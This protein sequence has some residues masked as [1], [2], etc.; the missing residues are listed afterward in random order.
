[1]V[2][3]FN[4]WRLS[5]K[6]LVA[7]AVIGFLLA[8]VTAAGIFAMWELGAIAT[9]HVERGIGGTE[10]L[11]RLTSAL[12]EHRI[13]IWSQTS[14]TSPQEERSYQDRFEKNKRDIADAL[15]HYAP[16]AGE[17]S[18]KLDALKRNITALE[19]VNARIFELHR[20]GAGAELSLIKGEGRRASETALGSAVDLVTA[21]QARA[22]V[23]NEKGQAFSAKIFA[24]VLALAAFGMAML[25]AIWRLIGKTVST[26]MAELSKA[27][28]T[29]ADG[30][31]AVVP[32]RARADELGEVAQAVEQFRIAAVSRAEADARAA[33]EQEV[34]TSSL[35]DGLSALSGGDL[36][37]EITRDFP[38]AYAELKS[39]FNEALVS[40]RRLIGAVMESTATIRTGSGEIAQA[41][42]DLA[43]RTEAN[44]AS[45]EETS[46]AIAQIDGR[47]KATAEAADRTVARAD[48]AITTVNGGRGIADEAVEAMNRVSESAK[49]IDDVI[50]G[51]DKIAFQTRVLAMNAAV[52]AGRA[53]EAGRGF[54]VVA[55]LVS[56]LAMRAEEEAGRAREQLT[57][58]RTDI[59]AAVEM[60]QK[61]DGAL[62][63]IS[64]DV[65]EVHALLGQMA[66]DNQ[67]QSTAITQIS[68][69]V[70]TMDQS[71]QQNAAMVEETSAAARNLSV[72]VT[73]LSEQA[74]KFNLGADTG[75]ASRETRDRQTSPRTRPILAPRSRTPMLAGA[76]A[77]G[78]WASF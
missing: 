59:V 7:F 61:V 54:A 32:H 10:A 9:R 71:T 27:T 13:I 14:A 24:A 22:K 44:A 57:A 43:R 21:H 4:S 30:G 31:E 8:S 41:S 64:S 33:A 69:A 77:A 37:C 1:M 23:N 19:Q 26:P 29:L 15:G 35:R 53:G 66:N 16:L 74:E 28:K 18:P 3:V 60:V 12:R 39:N 45:L 34:V 65:G 47:L 42:E 50:E 78:D 58:T 49:G 75:P 11:G 25:F 48:G 51:L 40:L 2:Q 68:V 62:A 6:M 55:D 70:G 52:E 5:K 17:L 46:A 63:D 56:A 72:E 67:A 20:Q 38:N 73:A 36:A 76:S